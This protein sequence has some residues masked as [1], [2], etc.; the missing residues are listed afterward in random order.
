MDTKFCVQNLLTMCSAEPVSPVHMHEV[1]FIR[2][3]DRSATL[4]L[5]IQSTIFEQRREDNS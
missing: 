4:S 3:L 1:S 2:Q 5:E